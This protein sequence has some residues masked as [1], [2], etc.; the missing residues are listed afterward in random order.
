MIQKKFRW[1]FTFEESKA[2]VEAKFQ[3]FCRSEDPADH[4]L[5]VGMLNMMKK[6]RPEER[7]I[8]IEV[9]AR[10]LPSRH[11]DDPQ[12]ECI[13]SFT[14]LFCF[15]LASPWVQ[16]IVW[17]TW[18]TVPNPKTRIHHDCLIAGT[19]RGLSAVL[20]IL[21]LQ[22]VESHIVPPISCS[23]EIKNKIN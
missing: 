21:W 7:L 11:G 6:L 1:P 12:R 18:I 2:L 13:R 17:R 10:N 19:V 9:A 14:H 23:R 20:G 22:I 8:L 3:D 15:P 4:T 16:N 5:L